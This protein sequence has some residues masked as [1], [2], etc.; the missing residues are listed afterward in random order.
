LVAIHPTSVHQTFI[1]HQP[2]KGK[3]NFS[4]IFFLPSSSLSF[5]K[6]KSLFLI[7]KCKY[8]FLF[9]RQKK[10]VKHLCTERKLELHGK[11]IMY[12]AKKKDRKV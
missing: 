2:K 8:A 3:A 9:R 5:K 12:L 7:S 11:I 1:I 6:E 10:I 4:D